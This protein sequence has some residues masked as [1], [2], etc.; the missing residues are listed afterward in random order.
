MNY[1]IETGLRGLRRHPRTMALSILTLGLGLASVMTM[2]S[3]LA[4][5][6][7]D[8]LPGISQQL[9]LGWVDSRKLGQTGDGR[10]DDA[11]NP[12]RLWKLA[13]AE[14]VAAAQP[15]T[16]QT[17][18]VATALDV[19]NEDG[20]R[21]NPRAILASG[22]MP[23]MFGVP[24]LHGRYWTPQEERERAPVVILDT[25]T[26]Q[27]LLGT[28]DGIDRNVRIGKAMFRVIG[29]SGE[30]NPQPHVY[31]LQEDEAAWG[32]TFAVKAFLPLHA[33]IDAGVT[34]LSSQDCDRGGGGFRFNELDTEACRFLQVW[35]EL[36]TPQAVAAFGEAL[37]AYARDRHASGAFPRPAKS[38][39]Y[40]VPQWLSV[41]RV[42]PDNVHLNLWLA[43]GL[44]VLCMVNVA[45]LLAARFLRRASEL[46]VRRVLGATRRAI[47][48]PCLVEAGAAGLIGG[49]LALPLTLLGLWLIR[50]Q[51]QGYT[52]QAHLHPA[53]FLALLALA[54]LTGLLVGVIPSWR[55]AR[56][57]PALQVK[58][59]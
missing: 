4:M 25:S 50:Q 59:Q 42:V 28:P 37:Q 57:E 14:A 56:L 15:R 35:A 29:I 10:S 40:S 8:P 26:S 39:L 7:A 22:Q 46:G 36:A 52:E 30:W 6:S 55:A 9:Y 24:L 38:R 27:K 3:L 41:N 12:P 31:A 11:T 23:S 49:M 16:R 13:D 19:F 43:A 34:P 58:S 20:K 47:V 48:V 51:D 1:A 17:A 32:N 18:L 5:L 44:L 2:L 45:G 33:A 53:L 54:A 21:D